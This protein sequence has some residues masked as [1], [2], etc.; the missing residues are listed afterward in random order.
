AASS[1]S[2]AASAERGNCWYSRFPSRSHMWGSSSLDSPKTQCSPSA[3]NHILLSVPQTSSSGAW[4]LHVPEASLAADTQPS[5]WPSP[6]TCWTLPKL[7]SLDQNIE[8]KTLTCFLTTHSQPP[9]P[10]RAKT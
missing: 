10:S 9:R 6:I 2:L 5:P 3:H 4:P 7:G 8:G 1:S